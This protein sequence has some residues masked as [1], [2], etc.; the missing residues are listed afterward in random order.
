MKLC[1]PTMLDV[2][3][4]DNNY[5]YEYFNFDEEEKKIILGEV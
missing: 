2:D 1:M 3:Y 5:L 4:K